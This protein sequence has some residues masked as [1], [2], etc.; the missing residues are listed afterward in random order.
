VSDRDF[1]ADFPFC[2]A[3]IGIHLSRFNEDRVLCSTT[4]FGCIEFRDAFAIGSSLRPQKKNPDTA[5]LTRG[6]SGRLTKYRATD[7]ALGRVARP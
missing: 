5:E 6:K 1:A 2:S 3:M 4:K 7:G